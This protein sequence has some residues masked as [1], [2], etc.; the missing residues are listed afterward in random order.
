VALRGPLSSLDPPKTISFLLLS[1]ATL[2][3]EH[4]FPVQASSIKHANVCLNAG[5]VDFSIIRE[6]ENS[7]ADSRPTGSGLNSLALS[8]AQHKHNIA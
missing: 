7:R 8:A 1:I 4:I 3:T 5:E 6:S 2:W